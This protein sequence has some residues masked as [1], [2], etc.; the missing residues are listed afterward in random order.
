MAKAALFS[1]LRGWQGTCKSLLAAIPGLT[2]PPLTV[3]RMSTEWDMSPAM[4]SGHRSLLG[5]AIQSLP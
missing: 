2:T 3:P 5:F 4:D 1:D